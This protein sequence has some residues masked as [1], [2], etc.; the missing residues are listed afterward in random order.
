MLYRGHGLSFFGHSR[1]GKSTLKKR[2]YPA[3]KSLVDAG[4][5]S[6]Q[7]APKPLNKPVDDVEFGRFVTQ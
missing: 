2:G 1:R 5:T 3:Y 6:G 4:R 7:T